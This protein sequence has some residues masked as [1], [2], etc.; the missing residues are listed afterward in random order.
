MFRLDSPISDIGR[1]AKVMSRRLKKVGLETVQDL[2][3]Y[4]PFRYEDLS[5]LQPISD[6]QLGTV[7]SIR[8]RL[9]L[10]KSFRSPVK[11][12][13]VTEAV[14]ADASG[15][16]KAI[17]F[18]QPYL[19]KVLRPGIE[20]FLA[21]KVENPYYT[22]QITNPAYELA[23]EDA[24]TH[25]GRIVP[26]YSVTSDISQKQLRTLTRA[27]MPLAYE[28]K[29]WLPAAVLEKY[30]YPLVSQALASIHFP[31]DLVEAERAR[32]RFKFDEVFLLQLQLEQ[33][34]R[35]A[36]SAKSPVIGFREEETKKFVSTLPFALTDDQ[37]KVA[38]QV[39][40]D[41]NQ[42]VPMSRLVQGEVGSGKT[43]TAAIAMYNAALN[44]YQSAIMAPTEILAS[45]H[46]KTLT[47]LLPGLKV[48]LFT[49][50]I[51]SVSGNDSGKIGR[52]KLLNMIKDG[53]VNLVIGTQ[54]LIQD[55]AV[56]A[57]LG[58][59]V[60]D[61]QHRFGVAQRKLLTAKSGLPGFT[62][63]LLSMTATPIPRTLALSWYSDLD[64][65]EIR[66][67]PKGRK[68]IATKLVLENDRDK[69]YEFVRDQIKQGR[70]VYVICPLIDVSD[71]L[72][73]KAVTAEKQALEKVFPEFKV[74]LL[75]G[76]LKSADKDSVMATF[77][78]GQYHILV[79][80]SVIEVGVDVPN[81]TVMMIEGAER[82]GLSQLHQIRGR[83]GRGDH[84]SYCYV[85]P[86]ESAPSTMARLTA[87]VGCQDGFE[88]SQ[89]DLELRGPG[90]MYG[91]LQ[92]G[93]PELRL[94]EFTDFKTIKRAQDE[95]RSILDSD[96]ELLGLTELRSRVEA[97]NRKVHLE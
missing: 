83:V 51:Q 78:S 22:K 85:F 77:K 47:K 80:T 41:L 48:A 29:E 54:A 53:T 19:T 28:V 21:G 89:K 32:E 66:H 79:A 75:H 25:T 65:S 49:G 97:L 87:F 2:L 26:V 36:R 40:Q 8:G 9:E 63:H 69:T 14:I 90:E 31:S 11:R 96:P 68:K 92:S 35:A 3:F 5:R 7:A 64:L 73:V 23:R 95:A 94:T 55:D 45:Q 13:V 20:L 50:S 67:L 6:V 88:L 81:A 43:V 84:Q 82:F 17:W 33:L 39:L 34:R 56:F 46:Y 61:E 10:I 4:L 42:P 72:G 62:P 37:R 27:V 1:L 86:S 52:R 38:W 44:G 71:K 57:K 91:T 93:L 70:Q 58:L 15:Q 30:G 76:R 59:A 74:G 16:I 60:V 12:M 24:P 18:N